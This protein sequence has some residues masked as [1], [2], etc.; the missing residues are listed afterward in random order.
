MK[1]TVSSASTI[2][3]AACALSLVA[4]GSSDDGSDSPAPNDMM[5]PEDES[6]TPDDPMDGPE[7]ETSPLLDG[8]LTGTNGTMPCDPLLDTDYV[9]D[10]LCILP[11]EPGTGAFFHAGPTDYDNPDEVAQYI[12]E[13]GD[14]TTEY[15]VTESNNDDVVWFRDQHFRMRP[16]SHHLIMY[17]IDVP[18]GTEPPA[19]GWYTDGELSMGIPYGGSQV[20]AMDFPEL[21]QV[22]PEDKNLVRPLNAR[23]RFAFEM[24]YVNP[25][26]E[27]ILR[28]A[29]VNLMDN[30]VPESDRI[31]LGAP[32]LLGFQFN[33]PPGAR[34]VINFQYEMPLGD[35]GNEEEVRLVSFFGHRHSN[36]PRFS[37]WVNQ[38]GQRDLVYEDYN[39]AEAK[40]FFYNSVIQNPEP[41][42]AA[43]TA[44]AASGQLFLRSGDVLEWECEMYNTHDEPLTFGDGVYTKE[45]CNVFG[46]LAPMSLGAPAFMFGVGS[47]TTTTL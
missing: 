37:I 27:P 47:A 3:L 5:A 20:S 9:G 12:I 6:M 45:M 1:P 13:P 29:W 14:E 25:T 24:H 33:V 18:E 46:T 10:E 21:G 42:P 17:Q 38:D 7:E 40:E 16:G 26:Q 39:W 8:I 2:A 11:A 4:C 34:Q 31:I 43:G 32:F 41:D 35:T 36:A 28:E 22:A 19:I 44:G 30:P 15:H 23:T